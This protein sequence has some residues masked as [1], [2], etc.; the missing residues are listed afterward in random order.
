MCILVQ[1]IKI[2]GYAKQDIMNSRRTFIKQAGLLSAA[3]ALPISAS[4]MGLTKTYKLGLQ[5]FSIRDAMEKDPL[6]SLK[7]MIAV[8]YQDFETYGYDVEKDEYYGY[9]SKDFKAILDDLNVTATSGHYGFSDYFEASADD[10]KRYT[11]QCIKGADALAKNFITWPWLA[12][13]YRTLEHYKRLPAILSAIAEQVTAAGLGFA[14]HN[15]DFEFIDHDGENGYDIILNNTDP[16]LVKLQMDMYWVK[17]SSKLSP[18]ELIA[19]QP[20]RYVMWHIKDMDKKTRDYAELGNGSID[21]VEILSN[22]N[23]DALQHYYIEQGGNY[24]TNSMQS[25]TDS[26]KYFKKYLQRYL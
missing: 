23:K 26:A 15:H 16:D 12:P 1:R 8:G 9:K 13:Q 19:K 10:I 25:L 20:G 11:D 5:L 24:A 4:A 7:A 18:A 21:Y 2:L 17:H 3:A 6:A 14:Y 22:I